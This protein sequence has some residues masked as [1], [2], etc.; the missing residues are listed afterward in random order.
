LSDFITA[1]EHLGIILVLIV[2]ITTCIT[3]STTTRI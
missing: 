2:Y 1:I 3:N